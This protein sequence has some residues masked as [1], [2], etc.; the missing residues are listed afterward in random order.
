MSEHYDDLCELQ[1]K[2]A[3]LQQIVSS[4]EFLSIKAVKKF[5][6]LN[7]EFRKRI[8]EVSDVPLERKSGV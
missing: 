3:D 4:L 7:A 5:G 2:L 6:D 1:D 8:S